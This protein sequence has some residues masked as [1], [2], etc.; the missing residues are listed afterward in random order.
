MSQFKQYIDTINS[1]TELPGGDAEVENGG[2]V[3]AVDNKNTPTYG[4]LY[5]K[6]P[7]GGAYETNGT[8]FEIGSNVSKLNVH[9]NAAVSGKITTLSLEVTNNIGTQSTLVDSLYVSNIHATNLTGTGVVEFN[10]ISVNGISAATPNHEINISA[11]VSITDSLEVNSHGNITLSS[12]GSVNITSGDPTKI[13]GNTDIRSK[14]YVNTMAGVGLGESLGQAGFWVYTTDGNTY[15]Y[16]ITVRANNTYN[17]YST[18]INGDS[19]L[20][21]FGHGNNNVRLEWYN[22]ESDG[23]S[24]IVCVAKQAQQEDKWP[25]TIRINENGTNADSQVEIANKLKVTGNIEA[26]GVVEAIGGGVVKG[27][28]LRISGTYYTASFSNGVLTFSPA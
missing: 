11:P 15:S 13:I 24:A 17:S 28:Q 6:N 10:E 1:T 20:I 19:S 5:I 3:F 21:G 8:L 4:R 2:I 12:D 16:P 18:I 14:K 27:T 22:G 25:L 23:E 7:F 26:S 9:G